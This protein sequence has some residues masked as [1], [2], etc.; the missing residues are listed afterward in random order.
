MISTLS[1]YFDILPKELTINVLV[2]V[3]YESNDFV[4][5][6]Q[7]KEPIINNIL[8][9]Y[10]FWK[11][12]LSIDLNT[13]IGID[14]DN[15]NKDLKMMINTNDYRTF[16]C[17]FG[18]YKKIVKAYKSALSI[19][20]D[21][22]IELE[23]SLREESYE[24]IFI[25]NHTTRFTH[26][27]TRYDRNIDSHSSSFRN[28]HKYYEDELENDIIEFDINNA[29]IKDFTNIFSAIIS[30][31]AATEL[32]LIMRDSS[33]VSFEI[34]IPSNE[35]IYITHLF[36]PIQGYDSISFMMN[37]KQFFSFLYDILKNN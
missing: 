32:M 36:H 6:Y 34:I 28:L 31:E 26:D 24:N 15:I 9:D 4:D 29:I 21:I 18:T 5:L 20:N 33:R 22:N 16:L 23:K 1:S 3:D 14:V 27:D 25:L 19:Y 30:E 13:L 11:H 12:K 7:L 35:N 37:Q 8:N 10:Y 2:Y 17:Y